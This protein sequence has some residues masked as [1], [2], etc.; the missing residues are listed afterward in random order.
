MDIAQPLAALADPSRRS[1]FELLHKTPASVRELTDQLP[2]SQPAV[3][4]H[5]KI[6]TTA[7]LVS[8]TPD[9]ARRIYAANPAGLAQLRSWIDSMWTDV[10]DH[11]EQAARKDANL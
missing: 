3:S 9:G 10:L 1:I 2:I 4:Q 7:G 6:L 5:L 11:F 8:S